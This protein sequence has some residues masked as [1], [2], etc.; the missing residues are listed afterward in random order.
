MPRGDRPVFCSNCYNSVREKQEAAEQAAAQ[1]L[2]AVVSG[3]SS[4]SANAS[5]EVTEREANVVVPSSEP[6]TE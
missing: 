2:A 6:S 3:A 1:R 5:D 4:A